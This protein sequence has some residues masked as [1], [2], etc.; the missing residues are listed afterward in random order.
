MNKSEAMKQIHD[1]LVD[2]QQSPLYQYRVEN[3]YHPVVGEGDYDASIFFIG[4]APGK[5]EAK[6]ARP[7]CGASGRVLDELL[8]SI[9]LDRDTVYITNVVKDRPPKNRDPQ[10]AEIALYTP[11]LVR[12]INIIQPQVVAT[13]GRFAMDF[14]FD[15]FT[16]QISD[17]PSISAARALSYDLATDQGV[18]FK[19]VPLY[20]PAVALYNGSK[21]P[22]LMQDF[23]KLAKIL[24][25]K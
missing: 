21:K 17:R 23:Q 13:L 6:T 24:A 10:P 8:V 1:E 5:T 16:H 7:F 11:F 25:D 22:E 20:H 12:Q 9:K 18:S 14:M 15:N 4:E 2:F 3:N 19:L